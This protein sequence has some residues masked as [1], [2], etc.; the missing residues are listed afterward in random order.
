M[1]PNHSTTSLAC[2]FGW[3]KAPKNSIARHLAL[4]SSFC[5]ATAGSNEQNHSNFDLRFFY[6]PE[7]PNRA[8]STFRRNNVPRL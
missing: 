4:R 5:F 8:A 2:V 1:T 3:S 7:G 6:A